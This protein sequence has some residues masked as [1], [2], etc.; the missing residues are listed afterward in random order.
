MNQALLAV[1]NFIVKYKWQIITIIAVIV[2][3]YYLRKNWYK[4][5]N[6]FA[7]R[8]VNVEPGENLDLTTQ[9]ENE[10]KALAKAI[11][12]DLYDTPVFGG[13]DIQLYKQA[14]ALSDNKLIFLATYYKRFLSSGNSL[15]EDI[16]SDYFATT[17]V[18]TVLLAHLSKVGE[19]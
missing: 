5:K 12:T 6:F 9:E 2:L 18:N 8:D 3:I 4:I 10:L 1:W 16:D 17:N 11:Y 19:R 14:D 7:P 13:H 15:Y